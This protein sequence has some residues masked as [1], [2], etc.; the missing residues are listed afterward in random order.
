MELVIAF[1][2][3]SMQIALVID[4]V[5]RDSERLIALLIKEGFEAVLCANGKSIE[6]ELEAPNGR[7]TIAFISA[8]IEGPPFPL[9][10]VVRC[11]QQ[12][13]AMPVVILSGS[14]D[15]SLAARASVLG[16]ADLLEKPLD[17][18]RVRS[19][20]RDLL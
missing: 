12:F 3:L 19:C 4:S 10:L 17:A 6:K 13:P 7:F 8:D 2:G 15:A 18:L 5:A 16:A 9:E 1:P 14:L 20:L 11:R